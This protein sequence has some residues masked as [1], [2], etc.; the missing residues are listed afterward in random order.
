[1]F[2]YDEVDGGVGNG[3][4]LVEKLS[5]SRRIVKKSKKPQRL[6]K[7]ERSWVRRNV[8][9]NTDLPSIEDLK[10]LLELW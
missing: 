6:K 8:Y 5:K 1:M 10:L 9:Q 4:K 3:G 7:L 2:E